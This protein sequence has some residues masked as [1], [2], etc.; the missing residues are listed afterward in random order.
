MRGFAVGILVVI[1]VS[2]LLEP[3]VEFAI[4]LSERVKFDSAL[5]NSVQLAKNE[6]LISDQI[7]DLGAEMNMDV[8]YDVFAETYSESLDVPYPTRVDNV[9]TF[10]S[11]TKFDT[12]TV[13]VDVVVDVEPF[14]GRTITNLDVEAVTDY[15]FKTTYLKLAE[16]EA[17]E[18]MTYQLVGQRSFIVS[19]VN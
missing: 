19:V 15:R 4:V 5:S 11:G 16:S 10:P 17:T 7:R 1:M 6:S 13:T 2:I 3:L 14:T 12:I 9:L 18:D 8:F